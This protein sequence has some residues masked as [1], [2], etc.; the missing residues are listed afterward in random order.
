M[1]RDSLDTFEFPHGPAWQTTT[2]VEER[3]P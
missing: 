2:T 1:R 3:Q